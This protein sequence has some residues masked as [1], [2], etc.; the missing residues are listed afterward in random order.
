VRSLSDQTNSVKY[1]SPISPTKARIF[2]LTEVAGYD[3]GK[4]H[5]GCV[6]QGLP[7]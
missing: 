5:P 7:C 6:V 4:G 1:I 3:I 2:V